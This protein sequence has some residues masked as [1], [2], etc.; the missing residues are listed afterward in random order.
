MCV[1]HREMLDRVLVKRLRD[2]DSDSEKEEESCSSQSK[3]LGTDKPTDILTTVKPTEAQ[4]R[5]YVRVTIH[6]QLCLSPTHFQVSV[7]VSRFKVKSLK[8]SVL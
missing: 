6:I 4:V 2:S 5:T 7:K 3:E 8:M 1:F